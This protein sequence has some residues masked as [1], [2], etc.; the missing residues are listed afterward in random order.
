MLKNGLRPVF[1]FGTLP[2][3]PFL[4]YNFPEVIKMTKKIFL[5]AI[6]AVGTLISNLFGGWSTAMTTLVIFMSIDY[7]TGFLVAAIFGKS[8]KSDNGALNSEAGFKGLCRKGVM[9]LVV[10]VACRLDMALNSNYIRDAVIIAFITNET[11][12]IIENAGLMGLPVPGVITRAIDLLKKEED[13][14]A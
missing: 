9:L 12:S 4:R 10:L 1:I 13:Q 8:T 7:I 5:C 6:G 11:I 14:D 2:R 3:S